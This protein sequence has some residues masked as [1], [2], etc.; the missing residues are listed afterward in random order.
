LEKEEFKD[1]LAQIRMAESYV[2]C[3]AHFFLGLF[4]STS[5]SLFTVIAPPVLIGLPLGM[6][7][8]TRVAAETFRR[9]CMSFDAWI[10]GY[11]L[12]KT[13]VQTMRVSEVTP[14]LSLSGVIAIDLALLYRFF[15]NRGIKAISPSVAVPLGDSSTKSSPFGTG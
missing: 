11:G 3:I 7:I 15:K 10:V 5:L 6:L 13:V 9:I 8:T 14:Y 2:T 4:S 1:A 12:S